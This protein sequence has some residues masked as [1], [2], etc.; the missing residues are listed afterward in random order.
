LALGTWSFAAEAPVLVSEVTLFGD[1]ECFKIETP[2]ATYLYGKR[3]AGF[4][5]ILDR[6]GSFSARRNR[7]T[8]CCS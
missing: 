2:H 4:A 1:M 5:S 6:N 8:A 7:R 3:G